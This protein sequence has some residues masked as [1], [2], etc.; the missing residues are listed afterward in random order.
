MK[1]ERLEVYQR[2]VKVNQEVRRK[3]LGLRMDLATKSQITRALLSI[4]S[5]IAEGTARGSD[6]QCRQF[7]AYAR[8][9]VAE[10]ISQF[11]VIRPERHFAMEDEDRWRQELVVISK[12]L[13]ALIRRLGSVGASK[14]EQS[15]MIQE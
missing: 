8:G 10:V 15:A 4:T 5:N 7:L 12:M 9:S 13:S 11:D 2:A 6:A 3:L 14:K 1:H